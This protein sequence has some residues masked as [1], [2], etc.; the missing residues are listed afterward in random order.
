MKTIEIKTQQMLAGSLSLG[1]EGSANDAEAPM[2]DEI[3]LGY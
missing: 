2:L 3:V 1:S